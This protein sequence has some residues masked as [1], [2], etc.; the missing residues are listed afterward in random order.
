MVSDVFPLA[1]SF[2]NTVNTTLWKDMEGTEKEGRKEASVCFG[3]AHSKPFFGPT[4]EM[5]ARLTGEIGKNGPAAK[6]L[7][8][9][10]LGAHIKGFSRNSKYRSDE[11]DYFDELPEC[12]E[13]DEAYKDL[14]EVSR[15]NPLTLSVPDAF[16]TSSSISEIW[17]FYLKIDF[18]TQT[19]LF[20]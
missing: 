6:G 1:A 10:I 17:N 13:I 2:S 20:T 3:H 7:R 11:D 9:S 5:T 15:V 16:P 19:C 8:V 4:A 18:K 14:E 12:L